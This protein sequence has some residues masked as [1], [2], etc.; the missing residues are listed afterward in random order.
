MACAKPEIDADGAELQWIVAAVSAGERLH[1]SPSKGSFDARCNVGPRHVAPVEQVLSPSFGIHAG[2]CHL[3]G[4]L[5]TA[6]S[7]SRPLQ[8]REEATERNVGCSLGHGARRISV[9]HVAR[10]ARKMIGHVPVLGGRRERRGAS[11]AVEVQDVLHNAGAGRRVRYR[12]AVCVVST[13]KSVLFS[14]RLL[15]HVAI[16]PHEA[17][18]DARVHA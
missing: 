9:P 12:D 4:V 3:P 7:S 18:Q 6:F 2:L 5:P 1:G 11:R 13:V 17:G 15:P 16:V 8:I 10:L 14:T